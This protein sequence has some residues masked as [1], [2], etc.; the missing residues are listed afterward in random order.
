VVRFPHET[1]K[2]GKRI[3]EPPSEPLSNCGFR[4]DRGSVDLGFMSKRLQALFL[5]EAEAALRTAMRT[6]YRKAREEL[7]VGARAELVAAIEALDKEAQE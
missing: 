4:S 3:F 2:R 7:K 1:E 6:A 5:P